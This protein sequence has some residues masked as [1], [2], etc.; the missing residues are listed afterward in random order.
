MIVRLLRLPSRAIV[1]VLVL[2]IRIYQRTLSP[3]LG[4]ACRFEPSCSRYMIG[5]LQKYGVFRGSWRGL[6][7]ICRCNPW[8]PGG[9]DPP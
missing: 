3:L 8:T 4:D 5:A 7:R 9:Y 6:K 1:A 2:I